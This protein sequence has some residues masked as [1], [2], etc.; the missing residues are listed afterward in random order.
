MYKFG[1]IQTTNPATDVEGI[2]TVA[3]AD[4]NQD[5]SLAAVFD[6]Y[7][8]ARFRVH[9]NP[10]YQ[11]F[12]AS[13]TNG[14]VNP[15][16]VALAVAPEYDNVSAVGTFAA[17]CERE[18]VSLHPIFGAPW[19]MDIRPKIKG[20]ATGSSALL[21][22]APWLDTSFINIPHYGFRYYLMNPLLPAQVC[23]LCQI[24]IEFW[25]ELRVVH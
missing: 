16:N 19:S 18:D 25:L 12:T 24:F 2:F 15:Q 7:R 10:L 22:D 1:D 8:I 9:F 4:L 14:V 6:Q 3:F 20:D 5:A 23:A 13:N 11:A 17:F 21:L